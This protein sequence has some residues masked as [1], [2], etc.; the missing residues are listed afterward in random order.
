[1]S[2]QNILYNA[3]EGGGQG[4]DLWSGMDMSTGP[5]AF[6][7]GSNWFMPFNLDPP[8]IADDI[9]AG[10]TAGFQGGYGFGMGGPP[11]IGENVEVLEG[12]E[13]SER[14]ADH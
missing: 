14:E 8:D 12:G 11:P 9:F 4:V 13:G 6:F 5:G 7:E 1:M 3:M 10:T 2:N